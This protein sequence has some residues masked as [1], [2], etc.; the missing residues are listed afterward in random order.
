MQASMLLAR[1]IGP[2]LVTIGIGM[3]VNG[4]VYQAMVGEAL[5]SHALI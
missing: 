1:I 3:L 2:P 4:R 5:H